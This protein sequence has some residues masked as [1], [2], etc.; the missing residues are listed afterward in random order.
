LLV[1][2]SERRAACGSPDPK[3]ENYDLRPGEAKEAAWE[4]P[5]EAE[6][7]R[8]SSLTAEESKPS[9]RA[10]SLHLSEWSPQDF[11]AQLSALIHSFPPKCFALA[12]PTFTLASP[13]PDRAVRG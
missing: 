1:N 5:V 12:P 7:N 3:A 13:S 11:Y 8:F 2:G 10:L 9:R 6:K 4:A